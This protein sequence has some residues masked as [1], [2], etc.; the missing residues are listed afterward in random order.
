MLR[1]AMATIAIAASSAMLL[2]ACAGLPTTGDVNV[3]LELGET[4]DDTDFLPLASGPATGAGPQEIVEG[5]MEAAITPADNWEIARRFLTPE[6]QRSWRPGTGVSVDTSAIDRTVTSS[7]AEDGDGAEG[8]DDTDDAEKAQ[9]ADVTVLLNQVASVDE[10][11][12]YSSAPGPSNLAFVLERAANGEWR[13]AQAPDGVVID[14]DLFAKVFEGYPLQY[15]DRTWTRLVPDVRWFPRRASIAT[16]VVQAL[17]GGSP[18]SWLDPAVQSAFP[19]DVQLAQD[20]VPI[21]ASQVAEVALTR[22]AASLDRETL[23]RM[24]TQ[25]QETLNAAGVHVSQVRFTVDGRSLDAGVVDVAETPP[26]AGPLVLADG[27]FGTVV[28]DEVSPIEGISD[29]ILAITSPIGSIDVAA[30]QSQAAVQLADGPVYLVGDGRVDELD[31]RPGLVAP[32]LDPYG[33][34]WTV[35]ANEPTALQAWGSDVTTHPITDAWPEASSVQRIRVSADGARI[36][37]VIV[38]GGQ[39]WVVVAAVVRD[40]KGLPTQL[41]PIKQLTRAEGE[42]E[43]LVWIGDYRLGILADPQDPD[44]LTQMVG[45]VGFAELAPS[46]ATALSGARSVSG[47]RVLDVEGVLF[48]HAGSAWREVA[49]GVIVLATRS[50]Q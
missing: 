15:F 17:I 35:P 48:A 41:G 12:E 5:F 7:V 27:A 19:A 1:R 24:R 3:G 26:D 21:N 14:Q 49:T 50:G 28:G 36:A 44:L 16:T 20:A 32:S 22:P 9:T 8:G 6:M 46:G 39:R 13:I 23:G 10:S 37:A 30:D 31:A 45:G 2:G 29:E 43:G 18:S 34:T 38:V 42:V 11:G 47:L 33:Y 4:T 40:D 25:L